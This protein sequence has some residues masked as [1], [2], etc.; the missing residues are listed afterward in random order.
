MQSTK[1]ALQ[2]K[3]NL[4]RSVL[5]ATKYEKQKTRISY[6]VVLKAATI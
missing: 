2:I 6:I 1:R 4:L 5:K 3:M